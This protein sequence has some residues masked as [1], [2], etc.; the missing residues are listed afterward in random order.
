MN[1]R[2]NKGCFVQSIKNNIIIFNEK[3]ESLHTLNET[4]SFMFKKTI[5]NWDKS[6]IIRSLMSHFEVNKNNAEKDLAVWL[7]EM[8][9]KRLL[10]KSK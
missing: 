6:K 9:K 5:K 7:A 8:I 4:A 2:L 3:G 10:I 1:Y